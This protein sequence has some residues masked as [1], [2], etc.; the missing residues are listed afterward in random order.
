MNQW[1][2]V[3]TTF[4]NTFDLQKQIPGQRLSLFTGLS[5]VVKS[6]NLFNE[7][8]VLPIF[9]NLTKTPLVSIDLSS[10]KTISRTIPN[11]GTDK[12]EYLFAQQPTTI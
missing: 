7:H 8:L 10:Q 9:S 11:L 12:G 1:G 6:F 5:G 3:I 4:Q 2:Q